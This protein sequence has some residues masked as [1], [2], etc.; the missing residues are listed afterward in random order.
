M[1]IT[2]NRTHFTV[3]QYS[4][5]F[6]LLQAIKIGNERFQC[7][8]AL[9]QPS[10]LGLESNGIH[11]IA[12]N[13]INKCDIDIRKN[14]Y[15]NIV[16]S[17]GSTLFPGLPYR[18]HEELTAFAPSSVRIWIVAPPERKYSVWIG[19]SIVAS[20]SN[21]KQMWID[22]EE[23]DESGPSIVHIKYF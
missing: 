18:M 15:A 10:F 17:G 11:E 7:A 12:Y 1:L 20:M 9:F 23:Y 14:L 21:Y 3:S 19:G 8:E 5:C 6:Y 16:L 22:K 2:Y 13:T 4:C